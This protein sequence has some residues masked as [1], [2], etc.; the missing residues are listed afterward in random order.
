M[1]SLREI[2]KEVNLLRDKSNKPIDEKIKPLVIGLRYH[3]IKTTASCQ[4]HYGRGF[5]YPRVSVEPGL[6]Y[7][8]LRLVALQNRP[9]LPGGLKN[10]NMWVLK[11]V[12][13][14]FRLI[15]ENKNLPL[16]E[17]QKQA[18]EFGIFLQRRDR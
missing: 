14:E 18:I 11:P 4:G 2:E 13:G 5:P 3:G 10:T 9:N 16:E 1:N 7:R 8:L 12:A 17:L 15:P 6:L